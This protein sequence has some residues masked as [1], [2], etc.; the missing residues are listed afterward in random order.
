LENKPDKTKQHFFVSHFVAY[1]L[2]LCNNGV[3]GLSTRSCLFMSSSLNLLFG[4]ALLSSS[5]P[6]SIIQH[7]HYHCAL[8]PFVHLSYSAIIQQQQALSASVRV[9]LTELLWTQRGAANENVDRRA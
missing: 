7:H 1:Q 8:V 2:F 4:L 9:A 3:W 5:L 6:P